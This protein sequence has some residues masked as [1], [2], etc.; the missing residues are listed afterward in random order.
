MVRPYED[1]AAGVG[2]GFAA[3]ALGAGVPPVLLMKP[4]TRAPAT[5]AKIANRM[6][7]FMVCKS[8]V[9]AAISPR[10]RVGFR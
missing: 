1:D 9:R 10:A 4:G 3:V 7:F 2:S 6:K 8:R 5:R